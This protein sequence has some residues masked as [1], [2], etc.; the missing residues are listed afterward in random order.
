M[1]CSNTPVDVYIL[2]H[3]KLHNDLLSQKLPL[4]SEQTYTPKSI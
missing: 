1:Q 4:S 3:V 2:L